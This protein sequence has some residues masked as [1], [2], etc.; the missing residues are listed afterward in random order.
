MH[1]FDI[2]ASSSPLGYSCAK[3]CFC[4]VPHCWASPRRK[5]TYSITHSVTRSVSLFDVQRTE[6]FAL[7]KLDIA[8]I[9]LSQLCDMAVSYLC[10]TVLSWHWQWAYGQQT[11]LLLWTPVK[12]LVFTPIPEYIGAHGVNNLQKAD[13]QQCS[14]LKVWCLTYVPPCRSLLTT[15]FIFIYT[16]HSEVL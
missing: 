13:T 6:A 11:T 4:H 14:S 2:R 3:F 1:I 10:F 12:F 7:E 5:I 16:I 15:L 8:I 9:A